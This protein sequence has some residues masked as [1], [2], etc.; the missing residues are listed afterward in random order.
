MF[1]FNTAPVPSPGAIA[2]GSLVRLV[3]LGRRRK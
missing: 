3:S 1:E 2:L